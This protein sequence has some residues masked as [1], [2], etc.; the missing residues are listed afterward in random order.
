[1][2]CNI[3]HIEQSSGRETHSNIRTTD[4]IA[5]ANGMTD[6][7]AEHMESQLKATGEFMLGGGAAPLF[8]VRPI[9]RA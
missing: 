2:R 6:A 8:A 3:F 1:M 7:E 4:E 5:E 9:H